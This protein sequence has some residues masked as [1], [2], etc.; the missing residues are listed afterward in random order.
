MAVGIVSGASADVDV[1]VGGQ[2]VL[3]TKL[4]I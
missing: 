4:W 2:G 1:K 3:T